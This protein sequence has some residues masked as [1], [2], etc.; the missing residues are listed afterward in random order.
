MTPRNLY[1]SDLI[2]QEEL[3]DEQEASVYTS[4]RSFDHTNRE[5]SVRQGKS[6]HV[7][8][9]VKQRQAD[10][11]EG[12]LKGL[13]CKGVKNNKSL[14]IPESWKDVY[15]QFVSLDSHLNMAKQRKSGVHN[16]V[17]L[18]LIS[19]MFRQGEHKR[20]SQKH[21]ARIMAVAPNLFTATW[22]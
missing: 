16:S 14:V 8:K 13:P 12:I 2:L 17:T 1:V 11:W 4:R 6:K 15:R 5:Y 7:Q 22:V 20:F 9:T 18:L 3:D 19:D 21:L 10:Y